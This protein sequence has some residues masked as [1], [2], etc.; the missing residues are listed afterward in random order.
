[1]SAYAKDIQLI[2]AK[3]QI[4]LTQNL[5]A[6]AKSS[7]RNPI[8]IG[9]D[10]LKLRRGPGKLKFREYLQYGLYDLAKWNDADRKRFLSAHIHW[11]LVNQCN[12]IKW[13]SVS[14]DKWISSALLSQC[15]V[16][17][18]QNVAIFD[19]GNRLYPKL[20]KL[21]SADD[22]RAFFLTCSEFPLFAKNMDG[23]WSAGAFR[24]SGC[25]DTHV[26]IDGQDP[27]TYAQMCDEVFGEQTYLLQSCLKPHSFFDGITESTATVRCLNLIGNDGLSVPFTLLK[28]PM[29]GNVADNFWR[30]GN[31]LCE[32]KPDTGEICSIVTQS[33]GVLQ[34]HEGLPNSERIL[35]GE[36]L[37]DWTALREVNETVALVHGANRFGST[38]IALTDSGPVV[39]EVNNGCAFELVQVATGKGFLTDEIR[40]F[41]ESCNVKF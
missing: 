15:G 18:P 13:W 37:P 17:V 33:N 36:C 29:S 3:G 16:A 12:D 20:A 7:G 31:V 27:M 1:M 41:F 2:E 34:R 30:S 10:Y 9:L 40:A 6:A 11:P 23:M 14:E 25:T 8:A 21:T 28:L 19:R 32:L 38:D 22:I 5:A 24:I 26:L 35:M 39:V 4:D